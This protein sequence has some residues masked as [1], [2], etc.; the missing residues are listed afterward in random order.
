MTN[1]PAVNVALSAGAACWSSGTPQSCSQCVALSR[2]RAHMLDALIALYVAHEIVAFI[3]CYSATRKGYL[4]CMQSMQ[5]QKTR[6]H[7]QQRPT[8]ASSALGSWC[9]EERSYSLYLYSFFKSKFEGAELSCSVLE[10]LSCFL[11]I[12]GFCFC[13]CF[14][15]KPAHI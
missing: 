2:L 14:C 1:P 11:K 12:L 10:C 3:F 6:V 13:L 8:P 15:G 7:L 5:N 4:G 9:R